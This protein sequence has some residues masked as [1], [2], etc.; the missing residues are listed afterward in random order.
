MARRHAW[1]QPGS[2]G[3]TQWL[4]L[5]TE[6]REAGR[7]AMC[8]AKRL[9]CLLWSGSFSKLVVPEAARKLELWIPRIHWVPGWNLPE[10]C[11]QP[12]R[13]GGAAPGGPPPDLGAPRCCR[14]AWL[15]GGKL[16]GRAPPR[17]GLWPTVWRQVDRRPDGLQGPEPL[18]GQEARTAAELDEELP[19]T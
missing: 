18:P 3:W 16:S 2:A 13:L 19:F 4:R 17:N 12:V 9:D 7:R 5:T 6:L 15:L 11:S 10:E 8:E 14:R 1:G